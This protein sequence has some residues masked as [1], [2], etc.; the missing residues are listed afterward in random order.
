M[1]K[2]VRKLFI[3]IILLHSLHVV[4][5]QQ[6]K[7]D[8]LK[9]LLASANN[10]TSKLVCLN[11]LFY[12]YLYSYPDSAIVY[13]QQEISVA[14]KMQSDI[15]LSGTY[16]SYADFFAIVGDFPQALH[17]VQE[18]MKLAEKSKSWLIKA[19]AYNRIGAI[20]RDE[21]DYDNAIL[22]CTKAKLII[23]QNW[24]PSFAKDLYT[25]GDF[26]GDTIVNYN[27]ILSAL[28]EIYEKQNQL[29]SS[30]RYLQILW[31]Q[32]VLSGNMDW[33]II[34]YYYGNIYRKK[35]DHISA[36]KYYHMSLALAE[37][38]LVN[39]DIMKISNGIAKTF[40]QIGNYDSS[41]FYANRV[42][43]VS[44]F[45]YNPLIKLEALNLLAGIYKSQNKT[46]SVAKYLG[47]I[48][49][50]KDSLFG[51]TK[52]IQLQS[53]RFDEQIRQQRQAQQQQA[54]QNK[55]KYAVLLTALFVFFLIGFLLYRN[56]RHKQQANVLLTKEKQK[57]ETTLSELKSAQQQLIQSEKMASLGELTAGI[58]HE[59]Q[60]P[61]NFV[62]NFSE[63]NTELIDE[64]KG[65]RQKA[66]GERNT[67]L[68][69]ELLNDIEE[70]ERKIN[71]HGKRADAIV[72]G[73]LQHSRSSTGQKEPTD[74]N[75]LADEY[76]RLAYHGLRAKDNSFNA[77][78][79]T[80]FD[81]TIG[82]INIIPQDIGRVLLNLF[83]NAFY[84]TSVKK[85]NSVD[86]NFEP[87]VTLS[88]R[89]TRSPSGGRVV[90]I[91]VIDNGGGIDAA[92]VS[93]IFQPFF[94]TKP[95]GQGTGLGLSLAYDIITKVYGGTIKV[96]S[97]EGKDSKFIIQLPIV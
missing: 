38:Q 24:N 1:Y 11:N 46:D 52:N 2:F 75:A 21:E 53:L 97:E 87:T 63:V 77:T 81:Q 68:E 95:T 47:F 29:D 8:S 48:I 59:I 69:N 66:G 5:G 23:E 79:K 93:K 44:Q 84:A 4:N 73:M 71:H 76:L 40:K 22:S 86:A 43:E 80:D 27:F 41:I 26:I 96:E 7:R 3:T 6:A 30:L 83:N 56:N 28:A 34:P 58:A 85:K 50:T 13:V 39:T 19:A 31:D 67:D 20:Y 17:Y 55:I 91:M 94:T 90:E 37:E 70:N 15:A 54:L 35:N 88:T 72:K 51:Q 25:G 57:V 89:N 14:K 42:I 9:N 78:M 18:S 36:L 61:L 49:S 16:L 45:G 64:L 12:E 62:N 33:S 74:I 82:N 92:I 60:N 10:D 65:E 32:S